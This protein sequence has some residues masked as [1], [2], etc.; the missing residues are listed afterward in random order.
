[1]DFGFASCVNC[2][3]QLPKINLCMFL[4]ILLDSVPL[5]NPTNPCDTGLVHQDGTGF[6]SA[7][8]LVGMRY[9][10]L[11][12]Q[13]CQAK[14]RKWVA[15][16]SPGVGSRVLWVAQRSDREPRQKATF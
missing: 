15:L 1:M 13:G 10:I 11:R 7:D 2:M 9:S 3:S 4:H 16:Y 14:F 6:C 12:L 5:E 8:L